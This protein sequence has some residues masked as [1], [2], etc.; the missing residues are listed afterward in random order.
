MG[1]FEQT[2][3]SASRNRTWN[4][5]AAAKRAGVMCAAMIV[6]AAGVLSL[7]LAD[8]HAGAATNNLTG[9]VVES[10][11]TTPAVNAGVSAG[12]P[13]VFCCNNTSTDQNGNYGFALADGT[14]N[15]TASPPSGDTTD[16]QT[17]VT[18]V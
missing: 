9:T 18:V 13:G 12:N 15:I 6:I 5:R 4:C 10:N 1:V 8:G 11:G 17:S 16:A 14:W 3:F 2:F 7:G